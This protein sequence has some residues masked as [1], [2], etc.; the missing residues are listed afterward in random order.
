MCESEQRQADAHEIVVTPEM[1]EAG[2]EV[3]CDYEPDTGV[4]LGELARVCFIAMA[5]E[6]PAADSL[7]Y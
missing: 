2:L 6:L 4:S 1:I 5:A 7:E 3:L